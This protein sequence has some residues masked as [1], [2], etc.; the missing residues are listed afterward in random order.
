MRKLLPL[1]I[2]ALLVMLLPQPGFAAPGLVQT[3]PQATAAGPMVD[4]IV[5]QG[6]GLSSIARTYCTTAEEIYAANR[7]VIGGNPDMLRVGTVLKIRNL[8]N[9]AGGDGK[10]M[11]PDRPPAKPSG[12]SKHME[13]GYQYG[14]AEEYLT[15]FE[16]YDHGP[17]KHAMGL[18]NGMYYIVAPNDT[19]YSIVERFGIAA[20]K[21]QEANG[22]RKTKYLTAGTHLYIPGLK[23]APGTCKDASI[24]ITRPSEGALLGGS[25]RV[26]GRAR[27]LKGNQVDI[28]VLA[29]TIILVE[30]TVALQGSNLDNGGEGVFQANVT[31]TGYHH[32]ATI[33]VFNRDCKNAH[34][35]VEVMIRPCRPY[36]TI[37]TP[38]T[39]D[40]LPQTFT[41]V[42]TGG[43]LF[44]GNVVVR[45]VSSAGAELASVPVTLEGSDVGAGGDGTY[46]VSLTVNDYLGNGRIEVSNQE[47]GVN[48]TVNVRFGGP[49]SLQITAPGGDAVLP[50]TFTVS[51]QGTNLLGSSVRV[52]I[53]KSDGNVLVNWTRFR[54][55]L[56]ADSAISS[57]CRVMPE[58]VK[59]KRIAR[60]PTCVIRSMLPS[61]T[62]PR[63]HRHQRLHHLPAAPRS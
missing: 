55:V 8:C 50:P 63:P 6:Q 59:S 44:E 17:R 34:D 14:S 23:E 56:T 61:L 43:C 46:S 22:I 9:R 4:H 30:Q 1:L 58:P 12:E 3:M 19:L 21:L 11:G 60:T 29:G 26:D 54:W 25:F 24:Q 27:N 32:T 52:R 51:G 5:V 62:A 33:K 16:V 41:V 7:G 15:Q 42:G 2:A 49:P 20:E 10:D 40:T 37:T 53:I 48:A 47:S 39:N 35:S 36:V 13:W 45:A 28:R 57:P 18:L 38:R 31:V